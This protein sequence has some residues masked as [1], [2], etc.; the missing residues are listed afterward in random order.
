MP[1]S[2]QSNVASMFNLLVNKLTRSQL[3]V[4]MN[5]LAEIGIK[6]LEK[7]NNDEYE[8]AKDTLVVY[9]RAYDAL[10]TNGKVPK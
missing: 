1:I 6:A 9:E 3:L 5:K 7:G 4:R 8:R 10:T 2:N